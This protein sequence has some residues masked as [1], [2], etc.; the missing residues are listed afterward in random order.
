MREQMKI[1]CFVYNKLRPKANGATAHQLILHCVD[2][3]GV[4]GKGGVFDALVRNCGKYI[5]DAY[6][7]AAEMKDL[8]CGQVH[9]I[10]NGN[11]Q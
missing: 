6:E 4:W 11:V 3:S 7:H 5:K 2:D 8:H 1:A 9:I 10:Q